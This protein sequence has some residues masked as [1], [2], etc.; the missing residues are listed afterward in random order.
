MANTGRGA[1]HAMVRILD[2]TDSSKLTLS[3]EGLRGVLRHV[4]ASPAE[5]RKATR[6]NSRSITAML[7]E[8]T[9][10]SAGIAPI[11]VN[12]EVV[13]RIIVATATRFRID[14]KQSKSISAKP[15]LTRLKAEYLE[16]R[17]VGVVDS[18]FVI[19]VGESVWHGMFHRR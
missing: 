2:A 5:H 4:E 10:M 6:R 18:V 16:E 3:V 19:I 14:L 15:V 7:I 11:S 12:V 13:V 1:R 9:D 8:M 17:S